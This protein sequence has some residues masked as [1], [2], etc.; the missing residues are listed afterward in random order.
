MKTDRI[1]GRYQGKQAGPL[2]IFI[3]GIHGNETAGVKALKEVFEILETQKPEI[4]GSIVGLA[5]NLRA[6]SQ[7]VRYIDED[8]NRLWFLEESNP[9]IHEF[10][11]RDELK[12][13]SKK[14]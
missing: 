3:A 1:I 14:S 11:E 2:L 10:K 9:E 4:H 8:L 6:L 12:E 7:E 5:G 13:A